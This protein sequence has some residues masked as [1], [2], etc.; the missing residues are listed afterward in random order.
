MASDRCCSGCLSVLRQFFLLLWKNLILQVRS[1]GA[2]VTDVYG[3]VMA[4]VF[5]CLA[6]CAFRPRRYGVPLELYASLS[7]PQLLSPCWSAY[8][9]QC[10]VTKTLLVK[11]FFKHRCV[12]IVHFSKLMEI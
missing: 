9:K 7:L 4:C 11:P 5:V 8:G 12:L 10:T 1:F 6:A 2:E 3:N